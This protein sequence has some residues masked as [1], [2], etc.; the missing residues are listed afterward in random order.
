MEKNFETRY[1]LARIEQC[2]A[3]LSSS[4]EEMTKLFL[5]A[6]WEQMKASGETTML[7]DVVRE[8]LASSVVTVS[9]IHDTLS[10]LG[11]ADYSLLFPRKK[12]VLRFLGAEDYSYDPELT[13]L[14]VPGTKEIHDIG[15]P[16][17]IVI[18]D[19]VEKIASGA[20]VYWRIQELV[21]PS[22]I[23]EIPP[24]VCSECGELKTVFLPEGI[25]KIGAFAFEN[26]HSLMEI[27]LPSTLTS[28]GYRA[29]EGCE[30]LSEETKRKILDIGGDDVFGENTK[31]DKKDDDS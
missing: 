17:R 27:N 6:I 9:D 30:S 28:I 8:Y 4:T 2:A 3:E 20:F 12:E 19:S 21:F 14:F 5:K 29:F 1:V 25:T 26:C 22:A 31:E 24:G 10:A 23:E 13:L 16:S 11:V 15:H 18:P 7:R